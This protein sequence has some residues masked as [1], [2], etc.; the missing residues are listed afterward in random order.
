MADRVLLL[1]GTRKGAFVLTA[2]TER[3]RWQVQAPAFA[4]TPV[5]H[6]TAARQA[7]GELA[8]YAAVNSLIWGADVAVSRDLGRTW[9]SLGRPKYAPEM[10]LSVE[11]VWHLTPGVEPGTLYAGVEPAGL[12]VSRDGGKTWEGLDGLNK[13]ESRGKWAP[14]NG[15]LCLHT[16]LVDPSNP[17]RMWI[18]I[19]AAGVFRTDD[20]GKTWAPANRGTR[21]DYLPEVY[22]E[23]GQCV[24][25]IALHPSRP[26]VLFQQSHC[27][28]YRTKDGGRQWEE[29]R[30]GLP[31]APSL[32]PTGEMN[33]ATPEMKPGQPATFGFPVAVHPRDPDTVYLVPL[34]SS[35]NRV[36]HQARPGV[37]R[38]TDGGET[39]EPRRRGLPQ[40]A[41]FTVL[42]DGLTVDTLEPAGVYVGTE[43]GTVFA[44]RDEG[45]SWYVLARDL[46]PVLSVT[47]LVV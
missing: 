33:G 10:G 37:Y 40:R 7:S 41:Y 45:D 5:Y 13:H 19:S 23:L 14:G 39:W 27:G 16:I 4:G 32:F 20:A 3:R 21:A 42:R 17:R 18:G 46:P 1:V 9:E 2:G 47:A 6:L 29:L 25:K 12:F 30:A 28:V 22:P 44:S 26:D 8:L 24:H 15:G 31:L 38:S 11:R 34:E 36:P 43:A 35:E